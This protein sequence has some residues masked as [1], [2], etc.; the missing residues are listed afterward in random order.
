MCSG[1]GGKDASGLAKFSIGKPRRCLFE[2]RHALQREYLD[3]F[4]LLDNVFCRDI[5]SDWFCLHEIEFDPVWLTI[6]L[7]GVVMFVVVRFC[8][9]APGCFC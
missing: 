7:L 5:V 1:S 9:N 6:W 3:L 2:W 8:E 4:A